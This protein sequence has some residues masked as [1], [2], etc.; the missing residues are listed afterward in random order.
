MN[1]GRIKKNWYREN[2]SFLSM[3]REMER[4]AERDGEPGGVRETRKA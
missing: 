2:V 1:I 3:Y 4:E